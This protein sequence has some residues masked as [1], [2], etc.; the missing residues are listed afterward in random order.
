MLLL[1]LIIYFQTATR[2]CHREGYLIFA[3]DEGSE[4]EHVPAEKSYIVTSREIQNLS[5]SAKLVILSGGWSVAGKP[6]YHKGYKIESA[7]IAAGKR[8]EESFWMFHALRKCLE[9]VGEWL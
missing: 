4:G 8:K 3:P 5:L 7:F 1:K 6:S 2:I 9:K